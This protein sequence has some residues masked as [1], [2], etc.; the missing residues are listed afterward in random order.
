MPFSYRRLG[1]FSRQDAKTAKKNIFRSSLAP[2]AALREKFSLPHGIADVEGR[3]RYWDYL[4]HGASA[5][6]VLRGA[7]CLSFFGCG[8]AALGAVR[9][10]IA[11][12]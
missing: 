11:N 7:I 12:A 9:V 1:L 3:T 10:M 6:R 2:F 4:F 5:L 8:S